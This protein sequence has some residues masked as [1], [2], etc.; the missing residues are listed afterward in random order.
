LVTANRP[1][2]PL[3]TFQVQ[4]S[5][6]LFRY[7]AITVTRSLAKTAIVL[8]AVPFSAVGAVWFLYLLGYN[9]SIAVWVG[10]IADSVLLRASRF[11][12]AWQ[13]DAP[14]VYSLC[15]SPGVR[16]REKYPPNHPPTD[17]LLQNIW[18]V[19]KGW[20]SDLG[21]GGQLVRVGLGIQRCYCVHRV[22]NMETEKIGVREFRENL[23]GYL[24]SGRPLA[25]TRH[26]ETLGF[27]IP[28][29]KRSRKAEV[30]AMRAA[31]KE[32]DAMIAEWGASEDELMQEYKQIRQPTRE[33]K[34]KPK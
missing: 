33:K 16:T 19:I 6:K 21:P 1:G 9:M 31:A 13:G 23:T 27:F 15:E 18:S 26:G 3:R 4:N 8:L 11:N 22:R 2:L 32:L 20:S 5:R 30:E 25:I 24:E 12:R 34:R 29:Q 14:W 28:A 7:L 17:V 10:L